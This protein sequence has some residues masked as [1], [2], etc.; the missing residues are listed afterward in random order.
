[1][2]DVII[3]VSKNDSGDFKM[4][5]NLKIN[6][7]YEEMIK[8]DEIS[9]KEI[10]NLEFNS[11]DITELVDTGIITR[12]RRGY[13]KIGDV[14]KLYGYGRLLIELR[15]R[16]DAMLCFE[17]CFSLDDTNIAAAHQLFINSIKINDY[18]S[19]IKYFD[20]LYKSDMNSKRYLFYLYLL[21]FIVDLPERYKEIVSAITYDDLKYDEN[22]EKNKYQNYII[23]LVMNGKLPYAFSKK[24]NIVYFEDYADRVMLK[25]ATASYAKYKASLEALIK[26]AKYVDAISLLKNEGS[27]RNLSIYNSYLM[28]LMED[29]LKIQETGQ[30]RDI[31]VTEHTV[32]MFNAINNNNYELALELCIEHN[33]KINLK[34]EDSMMFILLNR[35]VELKK[36]YVVEEVSKVEE[37]T[38][39]GVNV[40]KELIPFSD[41]VSSLINNDINFNNVLYDYL[42]GMN[43]LSY[44][45]FILKL[46]ELA[47]ID[48]KGYTD[49][50]IVMTQIVNGSY[51]FDENYY[52]KLFYESIG[53]NEVNKAT[54]YLDILEMSGCVY[55]LLIQ[56]LR[57]VVEVLSIKNEEVKKSVQVEVV[58]EPVKEVKTTTDKSNGEVVPSSQN[59]KV[60]KREFVKVTDEEEKFVRDKLELLNQNRG[61]I[62]LRPMDSTRRKNIHHI[63]ER[64]K[65][66]NSFSIGSD[67]NRRIVLRHNGCKYVDIKTVIKEADRLFYSKKYSEAL[68]L[69]LDILGT[70]NPKTFIF[71]KIGLTYLKMNNIENAIMYLTVATELAKVNNEDFD[72]SDLI[73]SLDGTIPEHE[74]K[75][76]FKMKEEEFVDDLSN[77]FG[78]EK[79]EEMYACATELGLSIEDACE[80]LEFTKE[81]YHLS[82]LLIA[83]KYYSEGSY[84][85]GDN[86]IKKLEKLDG[87]T[88]KVITKMEEVRRNRK[89]YVHRVDGVQKTMKSSN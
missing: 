31:V 28:Y 23:S 63:V 35:I 83:R 88:K 54:I 20:V 7:L 18:D 29:I 21:S 84:D 69:Y 22:D 49:V 60:Y 56:E 46:I 70:N 52:I 27:V 80:Q 87:K 53:I 12:V 89:F 15:R 64:I 77:Y 30:V 79:F 41:V 76:K 71:A 61:I 42:D 48:N 11:N 2:Y 50:L 19:A 36:Q 8:V 9:T 81:E 78:V 59:E 4:V 13:Y 32:N 62:V 58:E 73:A 43:L 86:Y 1:M 85:T 17:K 26:D 68:E 40:E 45:D 55:E 34:D 57:K 67:D 44:Y 72:F 25:E 5:N 82:L 14:S 24:N 3:L 74:K 47:N 51:S 37:L 6:K 33:K 39:D 66:L 38:D 75:P 65:E 10:K 16:E